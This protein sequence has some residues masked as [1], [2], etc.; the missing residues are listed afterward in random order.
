MQQAVPPT[1]RYFVSDLKPQDVVRST[2]M[3]KSKGVMQAKNGKPYLALILGDC[4]G[5]VDTR[6]WTNDVVELAAT[7]SEGDVIAVA[8]RAQWFQN[9]MQ[10]ILDNLAPVEEPVTLSDYLPKAGADAEKQYTE[11]ITLFEGLDCPWT[12]QLA[13]ALLKHPD[14]AS[15]YPVAPAAKTIHHAYLGGLLT[16]SLQL[17]KLVD[18]LLPLYPKLNRNVALFGA[19]FHDFGK[20]FELSYDGSF[21]YTDEGRLVGHIAIGTVL[22]DRAI[23]EIPEFPVALE[24]QLKHMVLSHHGKI[25]YGSPVRPQTLE[26]QFVHHLDDMDSKLNSIQELMDSERSTAAWTAVHKA[27]GTSYF[28][29]KADA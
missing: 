1:K 18:A 14:I 29:P 21:G 16:H 5:T 3:V 12:R 9:R 15:R 25:E 11:L 28:K 17:T 4:T 23:R 10:L 7:F 19:A 6:V 2:F 27:Y 24:L 26:A 22:I 8:G 13:V 20:I